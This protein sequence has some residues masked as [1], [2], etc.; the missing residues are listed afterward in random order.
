MRAK[1][2]KQ[3]IKE[4]ELEEEEDKWGDR[5]WV[6]EGVKYHTRQEAMK[7]VSELMAEEYRQ[8]YL[9]KGTK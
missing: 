4:I 7:A 3:H 1:N 8:R 9:E 6:V 2:L 5:V